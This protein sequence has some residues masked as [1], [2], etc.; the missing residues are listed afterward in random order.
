MAKPDEY[1]LVVVL[2]YLKRLE[3]DLF[4]NIFGQEWINRTNLVIIRNF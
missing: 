1:I 2:I 3:G 4:A